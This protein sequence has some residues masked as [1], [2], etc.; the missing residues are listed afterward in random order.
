MDEAPSFTTVKLIL[1][2]LHACIATNTGYVI[3][4]YIALVGPSEGVIVGMEKIPSILLVCFG[5]K[6]QVIVK[7]PNHTIDIY[8]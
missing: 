7:F 5:I 2:L 4:L 6:L 8:V 3:L 1:P